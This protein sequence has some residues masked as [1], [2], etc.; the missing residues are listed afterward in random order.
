VRYLTNDTNLV[1]DATLAATNVIASQSF[2]LTNRNATGGGIVSLTGSYT[3]SDDAVFDIEVTSTTINGAP[4]ISAP[5]FAGV[6]NGTIS[7]IGATSALAAQE[8]TV[9]VTDTGTETRAAWA[10]FQ[11]V[12]LE[13]QT[14]GTAGNDYTVRISQAGLTA[15]A[16]DYAV[17]V[18]MGR[19]G[20]EF[21]GEEFNFGAVTLEPEGTVP[22]T[23]PRIRFGD[24]VA[25]YRHWRSYRDGRYRYHLSPALRRDVPVGTR[26]YAITGGREVTVYDGATLT[27]THPNITTLY[28]LLTDIET[29]STLLNVDGV[30][31]NDRRPG[32]MACDDLSVYTASYVNG[33]TRDGTTYIRRAVVDLTVSAT[34]PTE[35]L[36]IECTGA[37]IPGA[38]I[39]SV[40]GSVSD[41]L[42]TVTTGEA[43]DAGDYGFTI[44]VELAPSTAPEGEFAAYLELLTRDAGTTVPSLCPKNPRLGSEAK[45]ATY[46]FEWRPRPAAACDCSTI[47]VSG[48][49]N[50]D[51]LGISTGGA[52]VATLPAAIKTLYDQIEDWRLASHHLNCYFTVTD[53]DT[54]ITSLLSGLREL[55]QGSATQPTD[56]YGGF[57]TALFQRVSAIA[58]FEQ[59]DIA[60]VELVANTFQQ[61]LSAIYTEMGGSGALDSAVELEFQTQWD[62]IV[63]KLSPL[64]IA[65]NTGA[66]TWK[67]QVFSTLQL[68]NDGGNPAAEVESIMMRAIAGARNLTSDLGPLTRLIQASIGK[69]YIA[70]NLLRPFE[71]ATR[72]GN[73]VW[74]DHG[75]DFW[76]VS[77]DGYLPIQPGYGYH[78]ARMQID[79]E[80]GEEV[81]TSTRE[82]YFGPA[83]GCVE[84]LVVGDKLI[85]KTTPYANGRS[86]YQQG[87]YIEWEIVRADPVALGGGQTGNDTITFS[88]RGSDVGALAPYSLYTPTPTSYSDGGLSFTVTPGGIDFATGDRWTFSAEGG[89]FRWRVDSGSWTTADIAATVALTAG[90]SASFAVGE[91]PSF[92]VGD[93]YQLTALAVNGAGQIRTPDDGAM[94]WSTS[95]ALTITPSPSTAVACLLIAHHTIA[96]TATITLAGSND[97]FATTP[98]SA[99]VPWSKG[100]IGYLLPTAATYAKWR[101]SISEAGSIGWVYLGS[102]AQLTLPGGKVENGDWRQRIYPQTAARSR[103]IAG[104]IVHS[105]VTQASFDALLTNFESALTDDDGRIGIVSAAGDGAFVRLDGDV[106][107]LTD[108]RLFQSA[109]ADRL[110][111]LTIP[112]AVV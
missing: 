14:V 99:T 72:Q 2:E 83:I 17:T 37:P 10:P 66:P 101:V 11:S 89:E 52:A 45:S 79:A 7:G 96:S 69:V 4:Q 6:G 82:Y 62:A 73:A 43:F 56:L 111:S 105:A 47:P 8:F 48:G 108:A 85:V 33:S 28:S 93:T 24:D 84:N 19:D 26:V 16:T 86:T 18:E 103:A 51:F 75:G 21:I 107:Q 58:K 46:V 13:A 92:E 67:T 71:S 44:P 12:N 68:P 39:W 98:F 94:A 30:I 35:L 38:E 29:N 36:R 95:Q 9:T 59:A 104:D 102:G 1:A 23:A 50:D 65:T 42:G 78:S 109:A 100:T 40:T 41:A 80:T 31:A 64:M 3:G 55:M 97:N 110:L 53:D 106:L 32:G 22:T 61:H 70:G 60:A 57:V 76:F 77:Q 74:Q 5:V 81:P 112:V 20:S 27:D 15:T 25:I 87:D 49:P 91:T 63:D 90:V 34:A 54:Y 88:V